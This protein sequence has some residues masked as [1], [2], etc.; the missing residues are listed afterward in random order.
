[1]KY[2]SQP[3]Y[4]AALN[5]QTLILT[6]SN[7]TN[8]EVV[9]VSSKCCLQSLDEHLKLIQWGMTS[10]W[11]LC[12]DF[13]SYF[14]TCTC[15]WWTFFLEYEFLP[16]IKCLKALKNQHRYR[17]K[18]HLCPEMHANKIHALYDRHKG[19]YP[20]PDPHHKASDSAIHEDIWKLQLIYVIWSTQGLSYVHFW[21]YLKRLWVSSLVVFSVYFFSRH[22]NKGCSTTGITHFSL[23]YIEG[24]TY[25]RMY[26]CTHVC[27]HGRS[28]NH[29]ITKI[30]RIDGLPHFLINGAPLLIFIVISEWWQLLNKLFNL[31]PSVKL[32]LSSIIIMQLFI[33]PRFMLSSTAE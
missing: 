16:P 2:Q 6:S 1:M 3:I 29:V 33:I 31:I 21:T 32:N 20:S 18:I 27:T 10:S 7:K 9:K 5:I 23:A 30:S 22:K 4:F 28:H 17:W 8:W 11:Q 12:D 13:L 25:R 19:V 15:T 14:E 24:W 26:V